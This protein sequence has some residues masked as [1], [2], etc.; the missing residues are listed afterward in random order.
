M[1]RALLIVLDSV[2]IGHAP[3]GADF[4]D[5]GANTLD[6]IR[7]AVPEFRIPNLDA[8][9]M[10]HAEALAAGNSI[11]DSNT[12]M[13]WGC[14][15]EQSA[16]KDTTTG[17]WE[18]A[19]APV[20][21]AFSTYEKF[22]EAMLAEMEE[23]SGVT[24]I[25]NYAQSG[26]AI[27]EEL[28]EEHLKTGNPILYTSADSVIQIAAHE[29]TVPL[30]K[31][32]D[33]CKKIR[34]LADN[35]QIGRVIARPFTGKAGNFIR[36]ANRH[37]FSI[38]PPRTIL[39]ILEDHGINT[40]GIGKISDIFAGSGISE[41]F[42]TK[43][44][45]DGMKRI[46]ELWR[47]P[48]DQPTFY[49]AN[50]VDFDMLY[51]HRR[52]IQGYAEALEEFDEWFGEFLSDEKDSLIMITADHG[53]DPTWTG[54]DHTRERVPILVGGLSSKQTN[55]GNRESFSDIAR[56]LAEWFDVPSEMIAG[57]AF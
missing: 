9:G 31:L 39:N 37:D 46:K 56:A 14:L 25:G 7:K 10:A 13:S 48:I 30:E 11:P 22:P 16:G 26:T 19:G 45:A 47:K 8:A 34:L 6:H 41:S 15:N 20:H 43:S 4:G 55:L 35:K 44:N 23:V 50:L 18:M 52:D 28:G 42:P 49:F 3:D 2:G 29:E 40:V 21:E 12:N 17:H 32:Y 53:N 51:G 24:F 36:T 5:E 1:K 54:T 38:Q 27:L 33:I 57:Q